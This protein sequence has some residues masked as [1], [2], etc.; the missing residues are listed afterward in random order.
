MGLIPIRGG[1]WTWITI[2]AWVESP[3]NTVNGCY[4]FYS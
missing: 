3:S 4:Y 1:K 2:S